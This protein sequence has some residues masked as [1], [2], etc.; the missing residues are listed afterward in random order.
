[1]NVCILGDGLTSLALAKMLVNKNILVDLI[2]EDKLIDYSNSRT[3]GITKKNIEFL[4]EFSF[5]I[6]IKIYIVD[7]N[8]KKEDLIKI[9][10]ILKNLKIH[11]KIINLNTD[12]FN[13]IKT[14]NKN[15]KIINI[16]SIIIIYSIS[17]YNINHV[18]IPNNIRHA[19]HNWIIIK[20]DER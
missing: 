20:Y 14:I 17:C 9:K 18:G 2:F 13:Q 5:Q 1:M 16:T 6:P 15:N 4:N 8:S 3:I 10:D 19:Y 7:H 12:N 11:T